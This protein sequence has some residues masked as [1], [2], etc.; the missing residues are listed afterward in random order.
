VAFDLDGLD[1]SVAPAVSAPALGGLSWDEADGL[2]AAVTERCRLAGAVITEY[3]PALDVNELTA[4]VASRLAIR[5]LS[6][7]SPDS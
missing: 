2:L 3:V 1:P 5:L 4:T 6:G 7:V